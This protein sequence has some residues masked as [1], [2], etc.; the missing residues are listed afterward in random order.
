MGNAAVTGLAACAGARFARGEF[1]AARIGRDRSLQRRA[2]IRGDSIC[3]LAE[4]LLPAE[5][6]LLARLEGLRLALNRE[7]MLGLFE[8]EL[9]YAR[10]P[11]GA[12]YQRHVD[13]P[14]GRNE[15][16]VTMILYL[17]RRWN[18][19]AGGELRVFEDGGAHHD[20]APIGG[21][22]VCFLTG[23]REHAVLPASCTRW[24]VSGWFRTRP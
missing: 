2:E 8:F 13:Q 23:G 3:W 4:P 12:G 19:Q 15:R 9:Q 16:R 6:A 21:R 24:S 5:T 1:R 7:A 14:R 18:A 10:Y 17:N 22:L 11:P 20:I